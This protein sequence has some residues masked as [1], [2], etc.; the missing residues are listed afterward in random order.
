MT[1]IEPWASQA[2]QVGNCRFPPTLAHKVAQRKYLLTGSRPRQLDAELGAYGTSARAPYMSARHPQRVKDS[3]GDLLS[4]PTHHCQPGWRTR[5]PLLA[6]ASHGYDWRLASPTFR[7]PFRNTLI[8]PD[9]NPM[10]RDGFEHIVNGH[11]IAH[12]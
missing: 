8:V 11:D 5:C 1:G 12:P 7:F 4:E 3:R 10:E 2:G 9:S 6:A